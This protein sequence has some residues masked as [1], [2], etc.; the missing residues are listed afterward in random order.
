MADFPGVEL[1]ALLGGT[2]AAVADAQQRL[3][4]DA[5]ARTQ[6][7]L[8]HGGGDDGDLVPPPLWYTCRTIAVEVELA[9]SVTR[10]STTV[11][12]SALPSQDARLV[13]RPLDPLSVSLYGYRASSALRVRLLVDARPRRIDEP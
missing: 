7:W 6:A 13:C 3:D 11:A 1:G 8:E 2:L 4:A 10:S 5:M 12:P 9:A